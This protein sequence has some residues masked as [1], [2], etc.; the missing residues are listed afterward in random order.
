MCCANRVFFFFFNLRG[1]QGASSLPN[2]RLEISVLLH[3]G[4]AFD[5]TGNLWKAGIFEERLH[6]SNSAVLATTG[7][8][9]KDTTDK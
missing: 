2:Q 6:Y 8:W 4:S 7:T 1:T 9:K 5:P 3:R